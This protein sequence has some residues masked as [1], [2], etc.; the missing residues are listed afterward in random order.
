MKFDKPNCPECGEVAAGTVDLIPARANFEE[1]LSDDGSFEYS[2]QTDVYWDGQYSVG[3]DGV[4][5]RY[6]DEP[7]TLECHAGHQWEAR[8]LPEVAR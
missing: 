5:S 3:P 8:L 1:E 6:V 4:H 7:M 2:G